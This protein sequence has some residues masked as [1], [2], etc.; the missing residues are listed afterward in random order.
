MEIKAFDGISIFTVLYTP[1]DPELKP[2]TVKVTANNAP[3]KEALIAMLQN[4]SPQAE[5]QKAKD[6]LHLDTSFYSSVVGTSHT[7]EK[8]AAV[9]QTITPYI[10]TANISFED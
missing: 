5:W 7:V 3:S 9:V 6:V 1:D 8:P 2:L 10:V 4:S